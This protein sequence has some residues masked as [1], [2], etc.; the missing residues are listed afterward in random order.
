MTTSRCRYAISFA[1]FISAL[2][3]A[4][5]A[6]AALTVNSDADAGGSCPATCTLRQAIAAA[7]SG[8]TINFAVGITTIALTSSELLI[9]KNL[10]ISGPGANLLSVQRSASAGNFRIVRISGNFQVTISGLTMANGNPAGVN[11]GGGISN[12]GTL[13]LTNAVV[14]GNMATGGG[15]IFNDGGTVT[16]RGSTISGNSVNIGAAGIQNNGGTVSVTNST[17]SGNMARS[18]NGGGIVNS[19][20]TTLTNSTIADNSA[21]GSGGGVHNF[22]G[23]VTSKNTIIALN[24]APSGPNIN[25]AL[26]SQGFNLIGTVDGN[27]AVT[28][29]TGDRMGVTAAELKLGPLEDNGGPTRTHALLPESAAIERGDSGTSPVDQRGLTRPVDSPT[30][31]NDGNGSDIGAYE[32]QADQLPGCN[33]GVYQV[34]NTEDSGAGSLRDTLATACA[35]STISFAANVRGAIT[36]TTGELLINK[37]VTING[38]GAN[39]LSVQRGTGNSRI[40]SSPDKK[41]TIDGLT[42][43]KG[44]IFNSAGGGLHN[45]G[46]LTISNSAISGNKAGEIGGGIR[47]VGT[48]TITNSTISGNTT[49]KAGGAISNEGTLTITNSTISG[50]TALGNGS[51][52]GGGI[53]NGSGGILTITNSTIASNTAPTAGGIYTVS[54]A[55]TVRN[56]IIAKNTVTGNSPDFN[57][58][59]TSQGFNLIGINSGATITQPPGTIG[60]QIGTSGGIIDPM[61]GDLQNNGG[62]TH[63]HA[64]LGGSTAIDRGHSSGFSIDQRGFPR[65]VDQPAG[66]ITGGDSGDIGAFELG[67]PPVRLANISTRLRVETNDNVLF[68]GFIITGTQAKKLIVRAIGPS[69]P[70]AGRLE[71]P[72]LELYSGSTLLA[73]NDN[74]MESPEKQAIIDSTIPPGNDLESAIVRSLAPGSYTAI[75]RGVNQSTGVGLVEI[76]DLDA[77]VDSKLAQISTRGFVQTGDDAMFGGL[78]VV[79]GSSQKVIVRAIGPSLPLLGKLADPTLEMYDGNGSLLGANDNWRTGEQEAEIIA[80]TVPPSDN[81]ESAIVRTL[82]PGPY[83]AIV[84]G[85]NNTTGIALVEVYALQ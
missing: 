63:T 43:A 49:S 81:L 12:L 40:F 27:G 23:T 13:T 76:Y 64:L 57:G 18:G 34:Q 73:S 41:L 17:I 80:T 68:G 52:F 19:G 33:G 44:D 24:N 71:N 35:G 55:V 5:S 3:V 54:T 38:P 67:P 36:L 61:L 48:A 85:V 70:V 1:S 74:W 42:I 72:T 46:T 10:T 82:A 39:L 29:A 16:I 78:Y 53:L 31:F 84:R 21:S 50:N 7:A 75:V 2:L 6:E 37:D 9:N 20:A 83:T 8:E 11:F 60:D 4:V 30:I 77:S 26:T 56:T 66:N 15:G 58:T 22:S 45:G 25:G 69:V 65:P 62:P 47:N 51:P 14:S 32:M 59:F 28:P 79:G